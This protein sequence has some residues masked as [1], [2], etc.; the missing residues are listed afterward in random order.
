MLRLQQKLLGSVSF[1]PDGVVGGG[2]AAPGDGKAAEAPAADAAPAASPAPDAKPA[3]APAAS[4]LD[5]AAAAA[6]PDAAKTPEPTK[7][8]PSL[9]EAANGKPPKKDDAGAAEKPA[10]AAKSDAKVADKDQPPADAAKPD[11]AKEPA[12]ADAKKADA[13]AKP[14]AKKDEAAKAPDAEKKADAEAQPPAPVKYEAFKLPDTIKV[15]EKELAKFT[16]II[17]AKQ[18]PQEDAQKLV[19]LY[20]GNVAKMYDAIRQEQRQTWDKLNDT[21]KTD[22]RNDPTL[23]G[24]R[25]ETNLSMAKAVIE[26]YGGNA[27]QIR[28]L[29]AHTTNNGMGNYPGFVRLLNNLGK[30]LN[31]FEDGIVPANPSQPKP[32]KEAGKRGWY[33]KSNMGDGARAP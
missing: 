26:E 17:G 29:L 28:D 19:D 24:N 15:D 18:L 16:D 3:E 1:A 14:D 7:S 23:G 5:G 11:A 2:N 22:L 12:K 33:D 21:W 13:E 27:E 32:V 10:E 30:A 8:E 4:A 6:V 25:L 31:I 20:A 9:L